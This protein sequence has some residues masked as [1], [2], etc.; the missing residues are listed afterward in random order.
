MA[1]QQN[2][3]TFVSIFGKLV[4]RGSVKA[5]TTQSSPHL[6]QDSF[7][8][9]HKLCHDL[10]PYTFLHSICLVHKLLLMINILCIP[11]HKNRGWLSASA[12]RPVNEL[13]RLGLKS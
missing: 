11:S 13:P 8:L 12:V 2:G 4:D 10:I 1:L 6:I 7:V 3:H 5:L 9:Y